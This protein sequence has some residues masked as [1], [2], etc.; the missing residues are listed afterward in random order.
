MDWFKRNSFLG[1]LALCTALA[2]GGALYFIFSAS[3]ELTLQ[4]DDYAAQSSGLRRILDAKPFPNETAVK[5][6]EE[7]SAQAGALLAGLEAA[8][9]GQTAPVDST[10]TPQGF[11][12]RLSSAT[13]ALQKKAED[14]GIPLPEDFYLGF[15]QYRA[16]PPPGAAAPLLGQQLD[17]INEVVS[18]L[19]DAGVKSIVSVSRPPLASEAGAEQ[20][21]EKDQAAKEPQMILAPFDIEFISGQSNFR[22]ALAAIISAEPLVV[23]KLLSVANSQPTPPPKQ[24]PGAETTTADAASDGA[25]QIPVLF[26]QETVTVKMRLAALSGAPAATPE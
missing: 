14:N 25:E 15:E 17:S 6:A 8:V 5:L 7:E 3:N 20:A 2:A 10:L 13:S 24:A 26:G 18:L 23:L 16:Q 9:A 22:G 11:Q 19:V 4:Q 12:D 21:E 1:G